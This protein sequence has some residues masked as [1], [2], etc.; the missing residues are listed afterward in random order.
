MKR[1]ARKVREEIT[2]VTA[3][4]ATLKSISAALWKP[5]SHWGSG[6]NRPRSVAS[7][8]VYPRCVA[9]GD[10][11]GNCAA[12]SPARSSLARARSLSRARARNPLPFPPPRRTVPKHLSGRVAFKILKAQN[13]ITRLKGPRRRHGSLN[14]ATQAP[15][16]T[17]TREISLK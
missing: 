10:V 15:A 4:C 2:R 5:P 8:R 3:V 13:C 11:R 17:N 9:F 14:A 7:P 12:P 1:F 16:V 6:H